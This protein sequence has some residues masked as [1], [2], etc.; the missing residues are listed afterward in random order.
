MSLN[1]ALE[2]FLS[3]CAVG[4][5]VSLYGFELVPGKKTK[6]LRVYIEKPSGVSSEDCVSVAKQI[7]ACAAVE[8][9]MV[10]QMHLEVSSPGVERRLFNL[11]H[12]EQQLGKTVSI[13]LRA[14]M[15]GQRNMKG[16]LTFV[17]ALDNTISITSTT[18]SVVHDL[19]WSDID[20]I[21]LIYIPGE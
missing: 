10:N 8:L 12:C 15:N 21:S 6:S 16:Q 1:H 9:P 17:S 2:T 5:D 18:D 13:R 11:N 19:D 20:K 3:Q 7:K 4:C 14:P